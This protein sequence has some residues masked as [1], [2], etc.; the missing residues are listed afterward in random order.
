VIFDHL[1]DCWILQA[2]ADQVDVL[3]IPWVDYTP[4]ETY[5]DCPACCPPLCADCAG[6]SSA[7]T[8]TFPEI[9][10]IEQVEPH[11]VV[12][13]TP[14]FSIGITQGGTTCQWTNF[15]ENPTDQCDNSGSP[16]TINNFS[17]TCIPSGSLQ[18][19]VVGWKFQF[20]PP[21]GGPGPSC[22][23]T[24]LVTGACPDGGYT[25]AEIVTGGYPWDIVLGVASGIKKATRGR[26]KPCGGC[27][28]RQMALNRVSQK[29]KETL[30][31]RYGQ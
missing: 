8:I 7:Y 13:I 27:K 22:K 12:C 25:S 30:N 20:G 15:I 17:A 11:D 24:S 10:Y 2:T 16:F 18:T 31:P 14:P 28:K 23:T 4:V 21:P 9:T 19:W 29:V 1:G 6:C 26:V 3:Q 5:P